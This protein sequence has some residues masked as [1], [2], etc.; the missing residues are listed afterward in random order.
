MFC[1]DDDADVNKAESGRTI[2]VFPAGQSTGVC[3]RQLLP[4]ALVRDVAANHS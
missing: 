1:S 2:T 3:G 4:K